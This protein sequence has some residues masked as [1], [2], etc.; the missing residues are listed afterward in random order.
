MSLR[1]GE[2]FHRH[3]NR[4]GATGLCFSELRLSSFECP[5]NCFK[6]KTRP[7]LKD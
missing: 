5:G 4:R 1:V 3:R 2:R 7:N 6:K